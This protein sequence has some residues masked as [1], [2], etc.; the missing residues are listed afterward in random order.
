MNGDEVIRQLETLPVGVELV[1]LVESLDPAVQAGNV[2]AALLSAEHR[3]TCH[4]RGRSLRSMA[5][6]AKTAEPRFAFLTASA[7]SSAIGCSATREAS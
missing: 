5:A 1:T 7:I 4:Y 6:P 3:L 2:L